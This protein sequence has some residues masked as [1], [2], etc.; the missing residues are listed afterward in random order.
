MF[1]NKI[2]SSQ[3]SVISTIFE[4]KSEQVYWSALTIYNESEFT[5]KVHFTILSQFSCNFIHH[6]FF[7]PPKVMDK[8]QK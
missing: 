5:P 8:T 1:L 6:I 7:S 3:E 2:N 4:N